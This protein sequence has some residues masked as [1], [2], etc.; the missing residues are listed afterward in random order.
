[1]PAVNDSDGGSSAD[2]EYDSYKAPEL[3][4]LIIPMEPCIRR[5]LH[6]CT[7]SSPAASALRVSPITSP[8]AITSHALRGLFA[9]SLPLHP[10]TASSAE[11]IVDTIRYL[12][13]HTSVLAPEILLVFKDT[14]GNGVG[15]PFILMQNLPSQ[16]C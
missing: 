1:M 8:A 5:S 3:A 13:A 4:K 9:H 14:N 15:A 7:T 11:Y 6:R 10:A 2:D 12:S 16:V